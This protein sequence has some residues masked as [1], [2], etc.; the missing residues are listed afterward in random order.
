MNIGEITARVIAET[1]RP[2]LQDLIQNTVVSS[3]RQVH[4]KADFVRDVVEETIVVP[5]P[6][7]F[8]RLT[9]PP[10]YRKF[11]AMAITDQYGRPLAKCSPVAA[12]SVI[13]NIGKMP[14]LT[15]TY[16]VT[17]QTYTVSGNSVF[18]LP[19][20]FLYVQY[21]ETP[22]LDNLGGTTWMTDLYPEVIINYALYKVHGKTG[23]D[24]KSQEVLRLHMQQLMELIN[25]QE[26]IM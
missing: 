15:P 14:D 11:A 1:G 9:L 18:P 5:T 24:T 26:V 12:T 8:V 10:R 25:D 20:Q 6:N 19:I 4:A 23:N 7:Q 17:G 21:L 2:D 13:D 3:I 16:Y 22:A